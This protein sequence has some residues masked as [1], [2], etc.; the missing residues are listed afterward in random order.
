MNKDLGIEVVDFSVKLAP[1]GGLFGRVEDDNLV[2]SRWNLHHS[3][4]CHFRK[5]PEGV[6]QGHPVN[7]GLQGVIP[8]RPQ[9][10]S[11][12]H[13]RSGGTT[14]YYINILATSARNREEYA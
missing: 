10:H 9:H 2:L 11:L 14:E 7:A 5:R 3:T 12:L 6:R 13:H 1:P 4:R 8:T